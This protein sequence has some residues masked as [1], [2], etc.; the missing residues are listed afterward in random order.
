[1]AMET[2]LGR[3][4]FPSLKH[5]K[6]EEDIQKQKVKYGQIKVFCKVSEECL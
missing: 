3:L 4:I 1:M 6:V 2:G 5:C